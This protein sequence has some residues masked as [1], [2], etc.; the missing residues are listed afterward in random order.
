MV[1][2]APLFL[3][4][5]SYLTGVLLKGLL[6]DDDGRVVRTCLIGTFFVVI[7]WEIII[8]VSAVYI[9]DFTFACRIFSFILLLILIASVILFR[10]TIKKHFEIKNAVQAMP[11][12]IIFLSIMASV[13][14]FMLLQPDTAGDS[15][16]ETIN[17]VMTR[18]SIFGYNPLTGQAYT[19]DNP[20]PVTD[21][22][23]TIQLF[24]A[25]ISKIFGA[26]ADTTVFV[27]MPI[28]VLI[29][30]IFAYSV[31]SD[32]FFEE[33]DKVMRTMFFV[34]G[35]II[36][37]I[38]GAFSKN[39]TFYYQT[40]KGFTGE[41]LCYSVLIPFAVFECFDGMR[42]RKWQSGIYIIMAFAV[43]LFVARIQ[44]GLV[45]FSI[46][47]ILAF[48]VSGGYQIGRYA[49]WRQ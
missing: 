13:V 43:T 5:I 21:K 42:N 47:L 3:I 10:K 15:S 49:K 9:D 25:Y 8:Q 36:L 29:L 46:A 26:G 44:T 34:C 11:L 48:L 33:D 28:W 23:I 18:N 12:I 40:L 24:Y 16:V 14:C 30:T 19:E 22:I 45:P 31:W 2:I 32:A 6:C 20:M 27:V 38:F 41:T 4:S 7:L 37:N 35:I 39:S 17:T 1:I